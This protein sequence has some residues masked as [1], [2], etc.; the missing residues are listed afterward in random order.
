MVESII[1]ASGKISVHG[2]LDRIRCPIV[3]IHG[4]ND[5]QIPLAYARR[6][7]AECVNSARAELHVQALADGGA[8]HCGIDNV[9]LTREFMSDWIAETLGGRLAV[10]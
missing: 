9:A 2:I 1:A 10:G 7:V 4:E 6:V 3:V 8:E 5:R